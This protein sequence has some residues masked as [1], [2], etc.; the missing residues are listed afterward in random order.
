MGPLVSYK[1]AGCKENRNDGLSGGRCGDM[2]VC[3]DWGFDGANA[4]GFFETMEE[5]A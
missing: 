5:R 4:D 3:C 1:V 2:R